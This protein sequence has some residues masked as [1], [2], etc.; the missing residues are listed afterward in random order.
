MSNRE[1]AELHKVKAA[2]ASESQ[3]FALSTEMQAKEELRLTLEKFQ[4][5]TRNDQES[6][7]HQVPAILKYR[8]LTDRSILIFCNLD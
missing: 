7:I 1:I 6:L 8:S 3:S 4:Q 5:Q 2:M